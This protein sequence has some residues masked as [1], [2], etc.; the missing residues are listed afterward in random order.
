MECPARG[1]IGKEN[2]HVHSQKDVCE[3][4]FSA[5]KG[6]IFYRLRYDPTI[7]MYVVILLAYGCP[8]DLLQ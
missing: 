2:I 7:V 5:S 3:Q 4:T 8:V 6:A 1:Q